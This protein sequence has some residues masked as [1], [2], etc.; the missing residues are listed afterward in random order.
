MA[1]L[2]PFAFLVLAACATTPPKPR[3]PA[4]APPPAVAPP[5]TDP[6]AAVPDFHRLKGRE[7][8]KKGDLPKVLKHWEAVRDLAPNDAEAAAEIAR[9]NVQIAA[10]AERHFQRGAEDFLKQSYARAKKEFLFA[11]Y[12]KPDHAGALGYLKGRMAGEDAFTYE[13]KKGDTLK[14]ISK[15]VYKDPQKDF[16][17]AYFNALKIDAPLEPPMTLRMPFLDS[18]PERKNSQPKSSP[19]SSSETAVQTKET[20][21]KARAAYREGNYPEAALLAE[22]ILEYDP[23]NRENQEIMNAAFYHWGKQLSQEGKYEDALKAFRRVEPGYRDVGRRLAQHRKQ[24]ADAHYKKGVKFFI[25]EE[26]ERA[27]R[28]WESTLALDP[29]HPKAKKDIESGR[30]L[31]LKLEKIK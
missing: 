18:P 29:H 30:S 1:C 31:L 22:K 7:E 23:A 14:S 12:L 6:F 10:E 5:E 24:V 28:E 15:K 8:E 27:I 21:D 26:I 9:L 20:L 4:P 25:E 11:L 13:V 19:E 2:F 3:A 16:L 17:I